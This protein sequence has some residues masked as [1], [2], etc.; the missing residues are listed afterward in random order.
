[1]TMHISF[2]R[3]DPGSHLHLIYIFSSNPLCYK[4]LNH[5]LPRCTIEFYE[6]CQLPLVIHQPGGGRSLI[7]YFDTR[8]NL[9]S[10]FLMEYLANRR[11]KILDGWH[12][13]SCIVMHV[14]SRRCNSLKANGNSH[15]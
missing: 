11:Q 15:N 7:V 1:M 10:F 14:Q 12:V 5:K 3:Q 9:F 13:Q 4:M 6:H 8:L 2:D